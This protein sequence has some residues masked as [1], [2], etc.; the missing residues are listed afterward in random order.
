MTVEEYAD[1]CEALGDTLDDLESLDKF[2]SGFDAMEDAL[3]E[4]KEWDPPEELQEFHEVRVRSVE[5]VLDALKELGF[6][7]LMRDFEKAAA[8]E[9]GAKTLELMSKMAELGDGMAELEDEM[10]AL[11]DEVNRTEEELSP[12]TREILADADCL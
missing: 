4:L 8:E 12:A 10:A 9:D 5:S 2:S 3:A 11:E 7:E 1:A 6:I